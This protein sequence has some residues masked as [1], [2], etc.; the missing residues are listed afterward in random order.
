MRSIRSSVQR[1]AHATGIFRSHEPENL[2]R[3]ENTPE[4]G[5]LICA[6]KKNY[7]SMQKRT[8]VLY[9]KAEGFIP[10]G[11][12]LIVGD[13]RVGSLPANGQILWVFDP[14]WPY[15]ECKFNHYTRRLCGRLLFGPTIAWLLFM[16]M[17]AFR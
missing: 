3:V 17:V 12:R 7:D 4:N 6:A 11:A 2:L 8:F 5:V 13:S 15:A 16:W 9:L 14:S 10:E 1:A